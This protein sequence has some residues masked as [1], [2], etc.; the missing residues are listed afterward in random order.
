MQ[1]KSGQIEFSSSI[2]DPRKRSFQAEKKLFSD[3]EN[4]LGE[5]RNDWVKQTLSSKH[6]RKKSDE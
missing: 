4:V 3:I 5:Y 6:G 2:N 1:T